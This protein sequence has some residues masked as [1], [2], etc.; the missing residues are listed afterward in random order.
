MV[1]KRGGAGAVF[2]NRPM[3]GGTHYA[4]W[5]A[6][7]ESTGG[8][9]LVVSVL[10]EEAERKGRSGGSRGL[11]RYGFLFQDLECNRPGKY[12]VTGKSEELTVMSGLEVQV[13]PVI[14]LPL[15]FL[16]FVED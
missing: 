10:W 6:D 5:A 16:T 4:V 11:R 7:G 1:Y 3:R 14:G 8:P 12:P 9:L 15:F 2:L 13:R